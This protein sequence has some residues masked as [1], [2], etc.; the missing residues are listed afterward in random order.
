MMAPPEVIV[1]GETPSL[2]RSIADLL[3]SGS[4]PC[5]LVGNLDAAHLDAGAER[6]GPVVIVACN[7]PYCLTARRWAAGE[8][9]HARLVVVGSRDPLLAT[10]KGLR[11]VPLPLV[12]GPLVNLTREL[13]SEIDATDDGDRPGRPTGTNVAY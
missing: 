2:G 11:V 12:P 9:P 3:Q 5:R 6:A 8:I 10:L 7:Q 1:V 13:L 4:I